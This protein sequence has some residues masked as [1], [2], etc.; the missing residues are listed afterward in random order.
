[1][2][3]YSAAV[4]TLVMSTVF[5]GACG[6]QQDQSQDA[7]EQDVLTQ[8]EQH[9]LETQNLETLDDRFSY[10]YGVQLAENF[11]KANIDLN[12]DLMA[13]AMRD[14]LE[15]SEPKMLP[16]EVMATVA[17]HQQVHEKKKAEER[18]IIGAK[19]KAEGEAF[20]TKNAE[21][22]GVVITESG[23]QYKVITE[24]S[25][26]YQPTSEDL[27][28]VHYRGIHVDGTEFDS[29]Y[30]RNEPYSS[31]VKKLIPGWIEAVQMMS[32]G[33]KWELTIP[34][35]LAY[36]EEGSGE[37]VGPN[38]VLIFEVELLEIEKRS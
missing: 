38:A 6:E 32:Q 35:D 28:T 34:A 13:T 17:E 29:T 19:N 31:R 18:A 23:L 3:K 10:A 22:E 37:Y 12:I 21:K 11:K 33:D 7:A 15:K 27:V 5:L 36:G 2:K 1:M 26:D 9:G 8:S 30:Q 20:L 4:A 24:G 25:G 14:V 16:E